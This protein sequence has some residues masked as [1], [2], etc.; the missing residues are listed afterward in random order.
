MSTRW[1]KRRGQAVNSKRAQKRSKLLASSAGGTSEAQPIDLEETGTL[2]FELAVEEIIDFTGEYS[3]LE[4]ANITGDDSV[5]QWEHNEK[6]PLVSEA[7]D[8]IHQCYQRGIMK[9]YQQMMMT[10]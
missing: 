1:R 4:V 10:V 7:A 3:G 5:V 8:E 2:Y 6:H 9:K